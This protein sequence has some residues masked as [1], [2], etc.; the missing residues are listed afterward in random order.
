MGRIAG[1]QNFL[2]RLERGGRTKGEI[3]ERGVCTRRQGFSGCKTSNTGEKMSE[4]P[5]TGLLERN[6][7]QI[8]VVGS[9]SIAPADQRV[10]DGQEW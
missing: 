4:G 6:C 10:D 1:I 7:V 9:Y 5:T 8:L 2:Y 3:S